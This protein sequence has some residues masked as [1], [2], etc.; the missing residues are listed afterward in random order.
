MS[1]QEQI[2]QDLKAAMKDKDDEKKSA[3]RV[4]IGEFGRAESKDLTDA[5]IFKIIKKMMKYEQESLEQSGGASASRY[6]RI[7][8]SY[9]PQVV[10]D[11]EIR[12]WITDNID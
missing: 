5:E 11:D 8:E 12:Q 2:R 1:L 4:L 7:L 10:S 9:L 3:L 6:L